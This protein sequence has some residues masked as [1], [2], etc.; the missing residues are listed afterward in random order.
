VYLTWPA[1]LE[2]LKKYPFLPNLTGY[3]VP[4]PVG[5]L[6]LLTPDPWP[7]PRSHPPENPASNNLF[8]GGSQKCQK[9]RV[10]LSNC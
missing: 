10:Q 5:G 1:V 8:L 9:R 2:D 3:P 4:L 6:R 7:T